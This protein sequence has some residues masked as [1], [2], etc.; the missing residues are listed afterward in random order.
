MATLQV[1]KTIVVQ[2]MAKFLVVNLLNNYI[3]LNE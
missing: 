2:G 3:T 1:Q